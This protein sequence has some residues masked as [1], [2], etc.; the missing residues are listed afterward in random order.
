MRR[1][2]F[3]GLVTAVLLILAGCI[4][5]GGFLTVFK[6]NFS[7]LFFNQYETK[8][9]V[10]NEDF[11][12]IS[13][14]TSTA[15]ITFAPSGNAA[16]TVVCNEGQNITHAVSVNGD[17]LVIE[18]KDTRKW[19]EYIG[20][21]W[22]TPKITVY[23]PKAEYCA[24]R[25]NE[26]TGNIEIPNHFEF[27]SADLSLSTGNAGFYAS[28]SGPVSIRTSTG[29]ISVENISAGTLDLSAS[30]GKITV[31]GVNCMGD[32]GINVTTGR[33]DLSDIRCKN[34]SSGGSTGSISLRN[35]LASEKLSVKRSTG[36]V[37]FDGSDAAEI[38]VKTSTGAVTGTL[39]SGKIFSADSSTGK[40]D[41]PS[42][43]GGG[44]CEIKTSTGKI[45]LD[46]L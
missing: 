9:H 34:L 7:K 33:V 42:S 12:A 36:S 28:A 13:M 40:V 10:I 16:C 5:F 14:H 11:S 1:T 29:N 22:K 39:L 38:S 6:S 3:T 21:H 45:E 44:K 19:Y 18:S 23:L 8:Q 32:A 31:S 25:I 20:F 35:V 37:K 30:T 15:D 4:I 27:E 17:T 26:S 43:T 24:L 2:T 46:I 41:V